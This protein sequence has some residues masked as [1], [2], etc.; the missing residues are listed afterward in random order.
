M[1]IG[2]MCCIFA[3]LFMYRRQKSAYGNKL[4]EDEK[5]ALAKGISLKFN[6]L[7]FVI[8]ACFDTLSSTLMY[9][10]LASI[11]ASVMQIINC[12]ILI[13]IAFFSIIYLKRRYTLEQYVGLAALVIG[14]AVVAVGAITRGNKGMSSNS[15]FGIICSLLAVI[16]GGLLM[17]SEEKLLS[18]FY[19]HPLQVV[20]IEGAAGFGM[21]MVLLTIFYFIP[22][23]PTKNFC[24]YGRLEDTP[25]AI[26]EI[27][28]NGPLFAMV[29]LAITSL[30]FFNYFGV[31]LT[32]Y[33]SATHRGAV[34]AVRPFT[35]WIFCLI[36]RWEV[37]SWIQ[38]V[39]YLISVY[40]MLLYYG[41]VPLN[42]FAKKKELVEANTKLTD[43]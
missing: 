33:A 41:I 38:L 37:F 1:F 8:P 14:V 36:V 18:V 4:T 5:A 26:M 25:R 42:P 24:V 7:W 27:G 31:S 40:G 16:F 20:G 28:T 10:G 19:A 21:F 39:G 11:D 22:C 15:P 34:N 35:V 29:L 32:K 30:G 17:V 12:T 43:E 2:E 13:W 3:F 23:Q 6:P 9:I